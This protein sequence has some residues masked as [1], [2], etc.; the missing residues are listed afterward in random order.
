[1]NQ[2]ELKSFRSLLKQRRQELITG[3]A[4]ADEGGLDEENFSDP[5]DRATF[6]SDRD[7]ILRIRERERKLIMKID[8]AMKR[9]DQGTYGRCES[10]NERIDLKR[11]KARPVT[12]FCIDCKSIQ[13]AEERKLART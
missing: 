6:E 3:K 5:T 2:K 13:E 1:L 4:N 10:C 7:S 8:S 11:L 9:I 12:T